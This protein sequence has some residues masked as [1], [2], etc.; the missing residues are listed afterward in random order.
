MAVA[1]GAFA[2]AGLVS[3]DN[4][5]SGV[6]EAAWVVAGK[7]GLDGAVVVDAAVVDDVSGAA[8]SSVVAD[9]DGLAGVVDVSGA[10]EEELDDAGGV[11]GIGTAGGTS[12]KPSPPGET[13]EGGGAAA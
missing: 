1:A 11:V 12:V 10:A 13:P 9:S 6:A 4:D 7:A 5:W 2:A 8:G 3:A